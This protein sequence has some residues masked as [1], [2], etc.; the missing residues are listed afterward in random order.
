MHLNPWQFINASIGGI[1]YGWVYRRYRNLWL[2]IFL[3]FYY[4]V[5]VDFM[6]VPYT[7][8]S[9]TKSSS[10]LVVYPLWFV[11]LGVLLF[12]LGLGL[13][14]GISRGERAGKA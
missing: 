4:N 11:L 13:A 2:T 14:W 3:H 7:V 8:L 1:F 9:N 5:L 6:T 10:V 12:L